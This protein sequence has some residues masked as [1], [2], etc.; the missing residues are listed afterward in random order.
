MDLNAQITASRQQL[1]AISTLITDI[2]TLRKQVKSR[3]DLSWMQRQEAD[4]ALT[5][6][7]IRTRE[8]LAR[9]A[10]DRGTMP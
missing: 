7:L 1:D 2:D 10:R 4:A 5:A 3:T 6:L 8:S 9:P